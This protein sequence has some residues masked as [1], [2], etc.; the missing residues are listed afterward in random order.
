MPKQPSRR[1]TT[2]L[3]EVLFVGLTGGIGSGKSEALAAFERQ[4]VPTLST[5][6]VVHDLLGSPEVRD[7]LHERWG[8][9]VLADGEVDRAAV[10]SIVFDRPEELSWLEGTIFPRVGERMVAWRAELAPEVGVAVVEVPLLFEAG[11]EGA[12]DTTV[13]VVADEALRAERAAARGHEGVEGRTG[14]QLTQEEKAQ[15]ADH[16]IRNDGSLSDLEAGVAKVL[17]ALRAR[18]NP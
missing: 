13:A 10:A 15:R 11:I 5:D 1:P 6:A 8:D 2:R 4:G 17:A 18:V 7:L 14:R 3:S 9:R 16:V 12:F